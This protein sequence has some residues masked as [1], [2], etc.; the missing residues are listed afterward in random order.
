MTINGEQ[1][2]TEGAIERKKEM[3]EKERHYLYAYTAA[4]NTSSTL[5]RGEKHQS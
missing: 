3:R 5:F 4:Y 1:K 2:D